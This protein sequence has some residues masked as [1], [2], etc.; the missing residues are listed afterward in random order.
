MSALSISN[1]RLVRVRR[2]EANGSLVGWISLLLGDELR[3]DGVALHNNGAGHYTLRFPE[4]TDRQGRRH[5][6]F[7]PV[8]DAARRAI[9]QAVFSALD[10]KDRP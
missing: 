9:E 7:F 8:T 6:L 1:I 3:V 4:R 5:P 10:L 2:E